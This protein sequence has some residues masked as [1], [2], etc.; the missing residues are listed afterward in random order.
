MAHPIFTKKSSAPSKSDLPAPCQDLLALE[1]PDGGDFDPEP[2]R[3]EPA[4]CIELCEEWL[5]R[6][7]A[8]PEFWERREA[9]R[10]PAEFDL[11]DPTR[12]PITYPAEFID[13]LLSPRR[14]IEA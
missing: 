3:T 9:D 11:I 13:E 5:P 14:E 2:Q 8:R 6:L 4:L 7:M 12:V 10:C 1:L